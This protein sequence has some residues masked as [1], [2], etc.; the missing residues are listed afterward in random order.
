M[1]I[2]YFAGQDN[3]GNRGCEALI[4]SSI[5][6]IRQYMPEAVFLVPAKSAKQDAVQ[7]PEAKNHGVTFISA[8][9]IP[10]TIRWWGRARRLW[11][12]LE[13]MPPK[14]KVSDLTL[15][16]IA[17]SDAL[18]MTGGDII[19][20]DYGL[21]SLYY[22]ARICEVAM[23]IG[24]PTILWAAS[25]GPFS[26]IPSAEARM[27]SFLNRFSLITVRETASLKYLQDLGIKNVELVIDSAF[28]LDFEQAPVNTVSLI[29]SG[30]QTLGF[31]VSPLIRNFREADDA[32]D[33]LDNEVADFLI[34]VLKDLGFKILLI[35][36]VDPL[37]G[38][39]DNSDSAY[40]RK[41]LEK[42]R[43]AGFGADQIDTLPRTLN[44]AQLKDVIRQCTYFMGARTHATVA[45]LSQGVPTTSIAYSVKAKGIN[46]DLFGHT[47]YVLDT[48]SV[49]S[50]TLMQ[51][52][53]LLINEAPEIRH[54]LNEHIPEWKQKSAKS[55][56]LLKALLAQV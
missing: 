17:H 30:I 11:R 20:L 14:F 28:S 4:R 44:A 39:A 45:A 31:N 50:A 3:F 7:W 26:K 32:K 41:I 5:K 34:D 9:P 25:V 48:P 36:H 35:P 51:H 46:Q 8:E 10:G 15:N 54:Y 12:R 27:K 42:V 55:A 56:L 18:V 16:S 19:S 49:N 53:H 47:R 40:M 52:L 43:Q 1:T 29:Q 23:D 21:E 24:K 38:S 6:T 13:G 37:D 33:I 2:I 22:W